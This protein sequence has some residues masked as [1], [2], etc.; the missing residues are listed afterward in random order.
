MK[1]KIALVCMA[2]NEDYY[3]QEW[4]NYHLK[5]GFDGIHIFQNN[6]RFQN[7]IENENVF[8]HEYDGI[9]E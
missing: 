7:K 2:K 9:T 3:L 1:K 8:F 4:I 5:L 6:W